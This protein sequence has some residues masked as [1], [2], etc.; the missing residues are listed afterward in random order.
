M[1]SPTSVLCLTTLTIA[2]FC[3]SDLVFSVMLLFFIQGNASLL[4]HIAVF[5]SLDNSKMSSGM[6]ICLLFVVSVNIVRGFHGGY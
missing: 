2:R 1:L 3:F 6:V 4:C 5:L